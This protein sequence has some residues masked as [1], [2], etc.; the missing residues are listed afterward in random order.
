[1]VLSLTSYADFQA[2]VH[3][4]GKTESVLYWEVAASNIFVLYAIMDDG[5]I[6]VTAGNLGPRPATFSADFPAAVALSGSF[7]ISG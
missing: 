4:L 1:M 5:G 2:A 7:G 3:S 6:A